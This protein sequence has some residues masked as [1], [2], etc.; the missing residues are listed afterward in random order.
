MDTQ[1]D[2][3]QNHSK[4]AGR[5]LDEKS[6][7]RLQQL[8]KALRNN[9]LSRPIESAAIA[10]PPVAL[11]MFVVQSFFENQHSFLHN[12]TP[13]ESFGLVVVSA[14]WGMMVSRKTGGNE[15]DAVLHSGRVVGAIEN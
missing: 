6:A 1:P 10:A 11:A 9:I 12:L 15:S 2:R 3:K 4:R 8:A 13:T 14:V 5:P 7:G